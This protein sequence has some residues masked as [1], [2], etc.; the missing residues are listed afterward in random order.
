MMKQIK[1]IAFF[2]L[3]IPF[4]ILIILI[5][6]SIVNEKIKSESDLTNFPAPGNIVDIKGNNLHIYSTGVK[7][8][9]L[10]TIVLEAGGG[11]CSADWQLVQNNVSSITRVCSWDRPG[12]GWSE[13]TDYPRTSLVAV[14]ELH[15]L[16]IKNGEKSPYLLVGHSYGG[17]TIRIFANLFPNEVYGLI[18]LDARPDN[19]LEIPLLKIIGAPQTERLKLFSFLSK[20]GIVR[21]IGHNMIPI[22]F[23]DKMP[24]YP[25]QICFRT[26]Y[27]DANISE[28]QN[29]ALSDEHA[30]K[31]KTQNSLPTI[32]IRHS[33]PDIF[34]ILSP[35]EYLQAEEEWVKSQ[36]KI[37][38]LSS[39][40]EIWIAKESGHNIHIEQPEIVIRAIVNLL[41]NN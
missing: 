14:K 41:N 15:E 5:G 25:T 8:D 10:P 30:R 12:Y 22:M 3:L 39:Q 21:L 6:Y 34:S 33:K 7:T 19:M 1:R 11:M 18:Y 13:M 24:N 9:S 37:S 38:A 40:S 28:A 2:L 32:V 35:Q 23:Q 36:E 29:I 27:F 31:H 26:K 16:L 4:S 17:H 20:I